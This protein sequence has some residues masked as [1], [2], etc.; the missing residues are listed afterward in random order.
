MAAALAVH[1][2]AVLAGG[3]SYDSGLA[4]A[5]YGLAQLVLAAGVGSGLLVS[6]HRQRLGMLLV[7]GS[8]A[9]LSALW[10]WFLIVTIP[11]GLGL[12]WLAYLRGRPSGPS[13]AGS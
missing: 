4:R 5:G 7:A 9:A 2:F 10:Y 6:P 3:G 1:G 12:V 13:T 8:I 11:V